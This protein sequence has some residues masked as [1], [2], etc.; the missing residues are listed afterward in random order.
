MCMILILLVTDLISHHSTLCYKLWLISKENHFI[1][2]TSIDNNGMI[3][4]VQN[5]C[6]TFH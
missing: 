6:R 2:T 3:E 1:L 4:N 5:Y